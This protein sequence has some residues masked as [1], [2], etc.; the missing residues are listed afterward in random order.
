MLYMFHLDCL[1][2]FPLIL[3][4]WFQHVKIS[5]D[6]GKFMKCSSY[7]HDYIT[8]IKI[9]V[10][11]F[12]ALDVIYYICFIF[13][14]FH[15]RRLLFIHFICFQ[16]I[17]I[18]TRKIH[19]FMMIMMFTTY[20]AQISMCIW[21]NALYNIDNLCY[22]T[23]VYLVPSTLTTVINLS[24]LCVQFYIIIIFPNYLS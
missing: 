7:T 11:F 16:R 10:H 24:Y 9:L 14:V 5:A 12:T 19:A 22:I 1:S 15:A 2:I 3:L 20:I 8:E 6:Q 13:S 17:K 18:S 23:S 21:S 4:F